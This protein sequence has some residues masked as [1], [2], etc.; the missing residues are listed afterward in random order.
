MG[1]GNGDGSLRVSAAGVSPL[2]SIALPLELVPTISYLGRIV[3]SWASHVL[4]SHLEPRSRY[5]IDMSGLKTDVDFGESQVLQI[6]LV[7]WIF[8]GIAFGA[9]CLKLF[10]RFDKKLA[11]WDDFFIFFSMVSMLNGNV[12][13]VESN[14]S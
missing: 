10:S 1:F 8:T 2:G 7:G 13:K 6:N 12:Y 4:L 11:G 5:S 3:P 9:V 14:Q